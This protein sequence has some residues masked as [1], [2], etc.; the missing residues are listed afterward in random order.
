MEIVGFPNYLIYPDGRV[1]SKNG[2]GRFLKP[3]PKNSKYY[4]VILRNNNKGKTLTIHRLI[5]QHYIPNPN[6][7]P[8][9]DHKNRIRTDN[10]IDNLRW[11]T[12]HMNSQNRSKLNT[13]TSGHSFISYDK[14][15]NNWRYEKTYDGKRY[16]KCSKSKIDCICYKYI[17]LLKLCVL[18]NT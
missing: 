5:A 2:K 11:A 4:Y 9:V 14:H 16:C 1:W 13:N 10:R 8:C 18:K 3:A 15:A 12:H 7:Y 17:I 6:D